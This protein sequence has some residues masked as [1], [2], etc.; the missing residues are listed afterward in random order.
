M[1]KTGRR[2]IVLMGVYIQLTLLVN[3]DSKLTLIS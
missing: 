3:W 1:F 2:N